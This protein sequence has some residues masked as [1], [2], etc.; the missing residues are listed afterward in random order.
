TVSGKPVTVNYAVTGGT[1][2]G[3]GVDYTLTN[4]TLTFPPGTGT[5][6]IAIDI[7]DDALNEASETINLALSSP[8]NATLG[9]ITTH[10]HTIFDNDGPPSVTLSLSG[11][12]ITEAVGETATVTATLSAVSSQTVTVNLA[13]SGSASMAGDYTWSGTSIVIPPGSTNGSITITAADDGWD[14]LDETIVVDVSSVANGIEA[15][16]Q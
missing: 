7:M 6:N 9:A 11:S 16:P 5:R 13:F 4:G 2:T 12:P 10:T 14:E 15:T 3:G 1:A 8:T